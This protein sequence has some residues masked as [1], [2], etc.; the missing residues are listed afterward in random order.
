MTSQPQRGASAQEDTLSA[1]PSNRKSYCCWT[2]HVSWL[3]IDKERQK[4]CQKSPTKIVMIF[5]IPF[6]LFG[7][8]GIPHPDWPSQSERLLINPI[9]PQRFNSFTAGALLITSSLDWCC[10]KP[11]DKVFTMFFSSKSSSTS[12]ISWFVHIQ[13]ANNKVLSDSA[14]YPLLWQSLATKL[15]MQGSYHSMYH[16]NMYRYVTYI[17]I[18]TYIIHQISLMY[19]VK[20]ICY[21]HIYI[22]MLEYMHSHTNF[23]SKS[24]HQN[25]AR[26]ASSSGRRCHH[27]WLLRREIVQVPSLPRKHG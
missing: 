26:I 20:Y 10:P 21:I 23:C 8:Y 11:T 17:Y 4:C 16:P 24:L 14:I 25:C 12:H 6:Y 9:N 13:P 7:D 18:Y 5:S 22:L 19:E 2:S 15:A 1:W 3:E 27:W